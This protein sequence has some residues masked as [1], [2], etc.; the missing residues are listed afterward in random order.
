MAIFNPKH[1]DKIIASVGNTIII[2]VK[3]DV[4][5]DDWGN[6]Y[7][8]LSSNVTTV[9]IVNDISGNEQFNSD[10]NWTADDKI[11]FFKSTETELN[12]EN[13]LTFDDN[14]YNMIK[15]IPYKAENEQQQYEVW[16]KRI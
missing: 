7:D 8:N 16:A 13:T 6:E 3:K 10:G 1:L 12:N 11:F 5:Y 14:N 15:I 9:A 4:T 2:R